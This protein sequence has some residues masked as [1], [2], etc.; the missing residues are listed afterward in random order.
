MFE[1]IFW[2]Y[3]EDIYGSTFTKPVKPQRQKWIERGV[4]TVMTILS[5]IIAV[6]TYLRGMDVIIFTLILFILPMFA[7]IP[8]YG[9]RRI[10][11][12][13]LDVYLQ[14]RLPRLIGLLEGEEYDLKNK[15]SIDWLIE[16][17]SD[18][19]GNTNNEPL[20]A[21]AKPLI[22]IMMLAFGAL[23]GKSDKQELMLITLVI[24]M[25]VFYIL[26]YTFYLDYVLGGDKRIAR[27]LIMDLKYIRTLLPD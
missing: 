26:I 4:L 8:V 27:R 16:C 14:Q 24:A 2:A 23:L 13:K 6:V 1:Y 9:N 5:I 11:L 19:I 20:T 3:K 12:S 7:L 15:K 25:L 21:I 17:C 22:P 10:Q 18:V